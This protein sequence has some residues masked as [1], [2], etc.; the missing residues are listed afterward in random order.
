MTPVRMEDHARA[1]WAWLA[2]DGAGALIQAW[3]STAP[4]RTPHARRVLG[5]G[6]AEPRR[7]RQHEGPLAAPAWRTCR[8]WLPQG[9]PWPWAPHT[10]HDAL[11]LRATREPL[12]HQPGGIGGL[13]ARRGVLKRLPGLGTALLT[14]APVPGG[15]CQQPRPPREGGG[16]GDGGAVVSPLLRAVHSS[17]PMAITAYRSNTKNANS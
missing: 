10:H 6:G 12:R 3:A 9:S 5:E 15:C 16:E 14:D 11:P 1:A 7:P 13:R 8:P 4:A 17:S 2:L